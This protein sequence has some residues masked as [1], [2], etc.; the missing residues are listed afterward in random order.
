M[1]SNLVRRL[2]AGIDVALGLERHKSALIAAAVLVAVL[3]S[4][5]L[6]AFRESQ[7][8][9]TSVLLLVL[10]VIAAAS[11]GV[12]KLGADPSLPPPGGDSGPQGSGGSLRR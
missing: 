1:A 10:P 2:D 9:A 4:A 3:M 8:A 12:R 7:T 11:T 6:A 5:V